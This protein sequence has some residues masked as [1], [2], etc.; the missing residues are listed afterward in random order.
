MDP[1]AIPLAQAR[2]GSCKQHP[3]P[4]LGSSTCPSPLASRQPHPEVLEVLWAQ[5]SV[6]CRL[7]SQHLGSSV[8]LSLFW[9]YVPPGFILGPFQNEVW[10]GKGSSISEAIFGKEKEE[11]E[12]E[13]SGGES[14]AEGRDPDDRLLMST[15][16]SPFTNSYEFLPPILRKRVRFLDQVS[17]PRA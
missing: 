14:W 4:C 3:H 10:H 17:V 9:V 13:R 6:L 1:S 5:A 11:Q 7:P 12:E 15:V 2:S 8:C 16:T